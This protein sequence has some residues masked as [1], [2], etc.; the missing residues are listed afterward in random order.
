MLTASDVP[1]ARASSLSKERTA[2]RGA[3]GPACQGAKSAPWLSACLRQEQGKPPASSAMLQQ[4]LLEGRAQLGSSGAGRDAGSPDA[5]PGPVCYRDT[6]HRS[7]QGALLGCWSKDAQALGAPPNHVG[8]SSHK[9]GSCGRLCCWHPSPGQRGSTLTA[10]PAC[11][12]LILGP[13]E[14]AGGE[15]LGTCPVH[16]Q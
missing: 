15:G 7:L 3:G 2:Q 13:A 5:S 6:G 10:Q 16:C 12:V 1:R 11:C 4:L 8:D 14:A 9:P